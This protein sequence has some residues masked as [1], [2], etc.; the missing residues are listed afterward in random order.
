[1]LQTAG[2]INQSSIYHSTQSS[3]LNEDE[4]VQED[5]KSKLYSPD[6]L[7]LPEALLAPI[8]SFQFIL[9]EAVACFLFLIFSFCLFTKIRETSPVFVNAYFHTLF[10]SIILINAP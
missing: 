6:K 5:V 4:F 3:I 1:L 9:L 8:P 2:A 7:E 10:L